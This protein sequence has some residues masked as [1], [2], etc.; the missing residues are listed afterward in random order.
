MKKLILVTALGFIGL[1]TAPVQ[2]ATTSGT[3][4]VNINVTAVCKLGTITPLAFAYTSLQTTAAT[5]TGGNFTLQ[6]TN[7]LPAPSL[8]LTLGSAAGPGTASVNTTDDKVSLDYT[9]TVPTVAAP[10]GS[11]VAYTIGGTMAAN[12]GGTCASSASCDNA[13]ATNKSYTLYVTY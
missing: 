1:L 9:V 6:C 3:F 8:G 4:N 2:A 5:A 12:Q 10:N 11:A 7:G 13:A